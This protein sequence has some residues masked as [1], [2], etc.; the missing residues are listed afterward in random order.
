MVNA[1]QLNHFGPNDENATDAYLGRCD[2]PSLW[3]NIGQ[4]SSAS[5]AVRGLMDSRGHREN[6]LRPVFNRVG[7]A[8]RLDRVSAYGPAMYCQVFTD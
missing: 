3:R 5:E 8:Y 7:L 2:L 4:A 6:I 1:S